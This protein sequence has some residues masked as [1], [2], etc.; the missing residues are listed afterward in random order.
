M[1]NMINNADNMESIDSKVNELYAQVSVAK[2]HYRTPENAQFI[3]DMESNIDALIEKKMKLSM[4][5][6][7]T[8]GR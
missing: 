4:C 1:F 7:P 3:A 2:M 6:V 5:A 8:I